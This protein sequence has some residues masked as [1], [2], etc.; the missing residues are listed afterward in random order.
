M[1]RLLIYSFGKMSTYFFIAP[2]LFATKVEIFSI[3]AA[4]KSNL[5]KAQAI[6]LTKTAYE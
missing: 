4:P 5:G 6:K 3:F 1:N 2:L